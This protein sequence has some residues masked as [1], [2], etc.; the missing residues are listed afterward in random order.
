MKIVEIITD[1]TS[2][3]GAE[4]FL[5]SLISNLKS[6]NENEV[7]LI[8]LWEKMDDSFSEYIKSNKIKHFDCGKKSSLSI[9]KPI[10]KLKKIIKDINPDI[11][12]THGSSIVSYFFAFG[13]RKKKWTVFHTFH[14]VAEKESNKLGVWVKRKLINANNLYCVGISK[15]ITD[16]ILKLYPMSSKSLATIYNGIDLKKPNNNVKKE[17]DIICV[18]R[19]EPQKNHMF[20]LKAMTEMSK[21]NM[22]PK[23]ILVGDG[24]L[25]NQCKSYVES[26]GLSNQIILTGAISN[27]YDYLI[28]SKVFVLVSTYEGNPISILEA[29]DAGLPIVSS[30]VGGIPDV[31]KN[32]RNGLLFD[33]NDTNDFIKKV[34]LLLSNESLRKKM[35][36]NNTN[37]IIKYSM[38]E[39]STKYNL[40]FRKTIK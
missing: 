3:A 31:V 30:N 28:K 23:A 38:K 32:N 25:L 8:T 36:E 37:D 6:N 19:F 5:L 2:R 15:I 7:F 39:C 1:L 26:N 35:S 40:L 27:I 14:N 20:L 24:S 18:A 29:M 9:V 13:K 4:V 16:T 21:R 11:I 17:F 12:H 33:V 10:K 34:E 22:F